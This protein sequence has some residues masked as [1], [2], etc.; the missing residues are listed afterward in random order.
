[1]NYD[2]AHLNHGIWRLVNGAA[3]TIGRWYRQV[4]TRSALMACSDRVL[5]DIGI[6][7]ENIPAVARASGGRAGS[8]IF[9][10]RDALARR[11]ERA[12]QRRRVYRELMAYSDSELDELGIGRGDIRGIARST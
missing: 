4:A 3:D 9:N 12:R 5:A 8:Q 6:E 2:R 11:L 7:R 1:M 10:W